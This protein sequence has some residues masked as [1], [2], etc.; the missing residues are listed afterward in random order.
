MLNRFFLLAAALCSPAAHADTDFRTLFVRAIDAPDGRAHAVI[1]GKV[2]RDIQQRIG[3][4]APVVA[5][6]R[7][8]ESWREAGCKRLAVKLSTPDYKMKTTA[9]QMQPF[10]VE[11]QMNVCRDGHPP[12]E[13]VDWSNV[14]AGAT[15][16]PSQP[17]LPR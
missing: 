3:T 8:V 7:T 5:E 14:H 10:G 4:T 11:F 12:A 1:E 15:G 2:A 13:T 6:V 17:D 16:E 9:G